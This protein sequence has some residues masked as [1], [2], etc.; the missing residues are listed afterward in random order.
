[1][2]ISHIY[3]VAQLVFDVHE[4]YNE[5]SKNALIKQ[6]GKLSFVIWNSNTHL[7]R[8]I[9]QSVSD[10]QLGLNEFESNIE[11]EQSIPNFQ[12]VEVEGE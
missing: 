8:K 12:I 2:N 10:L 5:W 3:K 1:M 7:Y 11:Q 4:N 6:D 9:L